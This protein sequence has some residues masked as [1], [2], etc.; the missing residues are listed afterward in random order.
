MKKI[1][2]QKYNGLAFYTITTDGKYLYIYISAINGGMYKIGTGQEGTK[3]GKIY[4]EK[5]VHFPIGTKVDEVNW[6]Y[7]KDKLYL[8]T[9][10]RDP[11]LL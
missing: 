8:K 9:S 4:A 10:S 1:H 6:V 11:W 7:L 2:F 3:A 5:N